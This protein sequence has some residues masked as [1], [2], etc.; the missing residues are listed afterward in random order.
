MT[1]SSSRPATYR[2][3]WTRSASPPTRSRPS[4]RWPRSSGFRRI[5][6]A[7]RARPPRHRRRGPDDA[8]RRST[9]CSW[10]SAW[11]GPC[12]CRS[13][14]K[15]SM[16][17]GRRSTSS[18]RP[19]RGR[20]P[21]ASWARHVLVIGAGNTAIDVATAAQRLGAE[22]VTIAYRRSEALIP[23]FAYEYQLAKA[24]GVRFEW[25]AQPVRILG[26]AAARSAGVEFLRTEL[27][28]PHSRSGR[29]R[30]VPGS[31]FVLPADMVVKA[32]GQEPLL[33][34]LAAL[35]RL[36]LRTRPDRRRSRPPGRRASPVSSPAATACGAAARS[37]MRSRTARS[38]RGAST[39][40]ARLKESP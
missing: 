40:C 29:V 22:T 8:R 17:S 3:A 16:A 31:N 23:A 21:S 37:S 13:R 2:A 1:S 10:A 18:S 9:P 24:D 7:D 33:D 5:G 39:R 30:T 36:A 12:R 4:S 34:L 28:D 38:R 25:F 11:A 35:A 27:E 14:A 19:T 32:L 26:D 6:I 20:S 15:T